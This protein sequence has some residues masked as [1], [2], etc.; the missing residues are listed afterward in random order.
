MFTKRLGHQCSCEAKLPISFCF[1]TFIS[2]DLYK[3][4][5]NIYIYYEEETSIKAQGPPF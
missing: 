5:N 3:I 2:Q 4:E 1:S